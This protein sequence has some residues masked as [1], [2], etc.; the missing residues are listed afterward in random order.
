MNN[1]LFGHADTIVLGQGVRADAVLDGDISFGS[2]Q[3]Y[4]SLFE[5]PVA[6][7]LALLPASVHP[8]IPGV[9]GVTFWNVIEGPL[10]PFEVALVGVACR[11]GIK[12]RH[13]I[14]AAF[15]STPQAVNWLRDHFGFPARLADVRLRESH[16]R[17]L[18]S[19]VENGVNVLEVETQAL[20]PIVGGNSFIKVSPPIAVVTGANGPELQQFEASYDFKRVLRG[21][22]RITAWQPNAL[23]RPQLQVPTH[24]IS[25]AHALVDFTVHPP[26]Y[27]MSLNQAIEIVGVRKLEVP[28]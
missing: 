26:R 17:I 28:V 16:D 1:D 3:I 5:F 9:V 14:H 22:P 13:L 4:Y 19:V 21:V 15:A 27:R 20:L 23:N 24:V 8:C 10:G 7:A 11:T 25:G 6:Q 12:P 18:G 2:A